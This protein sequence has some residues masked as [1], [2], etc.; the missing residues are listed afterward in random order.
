MRTIHL[1]WSTPISVIEQIQ[2][3]GD[4]ESLKEFCRVLKPGGTLV[5]QVPYRHQSEDILLS[6]DSKG[7]PL[8]EPRSYER[9][10]DEERLME[11]L[12]IEGLRVE[13][14]LIMGEWLSID[15]WINDAN[16]LPR[17]FRIALMLL[18]PLLAFMNY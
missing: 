17:M 4:V 18:E 15:P 12:E 5:I 16:R 14:R 8:P 6:C 7:K 10:Y 13:K 9:Y 11:R 3:D 1:I 2:G